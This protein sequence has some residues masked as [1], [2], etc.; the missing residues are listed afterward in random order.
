MKKIVLAFGFLTLGLM[1]TDFSTLTLEEL[2]ALRGSVAI[3]DQADYQTALSALI[4]ELSSDEVAQLLLVQPASLQGGASALNL[5][6]FDSDGDGVI[7]EDE[8]DTGIAEKLES[9][10]EE[11]RLL[12][13]LDNMSDFTT[14]DLN[15]DGVLDATELPSLN[16]TSSTPTPRGMTTPRRGR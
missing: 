16:L 2:L 11:G 13:N 14:L 6:S 15:G 7:T 9:Y 8:F 5:L 4:D 3:E 10:T 1:A 12:Q